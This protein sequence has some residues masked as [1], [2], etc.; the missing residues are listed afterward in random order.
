MEFEN[1]L[2]EYGNA[3]FFFQQCLSFRLF[4]NCVTKVDLSFDDIY[5][6]M[7]LSKNERKGEKIKLD[8]GELQLEGGCNW[9]CIVRL[10]DKWVSNG[11]R[12][13]Y[14]NRPNI[15]LQQRRFVGL[16]KI[17]LHVIFAFLIA[18]GLYWFYTFLYPVVPLITREWS[19]YNS[20]L[21][22]P[23]VWDTTLE[24]VVDQLRSQNATIPDVAT[25]VRWKEA[26]KEQKSL[27]VKASET[28]SYVRLISYLSSVIILFSLQ[29]YAIFE[30]VMNWVYGTNNETAQNILNDLYPFQRSV[31]G[32][33]QSP[34]RA[35]A[36]SPG[37]RAASPAR[38]AS[39]VQLNLT[40]AR[41]RLGGGYFDS[42]HNMNQIFRSVYMH[43]LS[44]ENQQLL[45]GS[46]WTYLG[47]FAKKAGCEG[48][49]ILQTI[50]LIMIV[51]VFVFY[52]SRRNWPQINGVPM[53]S[54]QINI[55][56]KIFVGNIFEGWGGTDAANNLGA[57][58][59][60]QGWAQ[61]SYSLFAM[62]RL[63]SKLIQPTL[64]KDSFDVTLGALFAAILYVIKDILYSGLSLASKIPKQIISIKNW[65]RDICTANDSPTIKDIDE[66]ILKQ[67]KSVVKNVQTKVKKQLNI[68]K[69]SRSRSPSKIKKTNS[70]VLRLREPSP[71]E[72]PKPPPKAQVVPVPLPRNFPF[73]ESRPNKLSVPPPPPPPGFQGIF[74][75]RPPQKV[76]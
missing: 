45:G 46:L 31:R 24:N 73:L 35:R 43:D 23:V 5:E 15:P 30:R 8:G 54:E 41:Q 20:K 4:N 16:V 68:E 37:R 10:F 55:A 61:F 33:S 22:S 62:G 29:F 56:L 11:I 50:I 19:E 74:P 13:S 32:R 58:L 64:P 47:N 49:A 44:N 76:V 57:I 25:I 40:N 69:V 63:I 67:V 38:G 21:T 70:E 60:N 51:S 39:G 66:K 48:L 7:I 26:A 14:G 2:F 53:T 18:Y 71:T 72:L 28:E 6:I 27:Y 17:A 34:G 65:F 59:R 52:G 3:K 42:Q 9:D 12:V 1:A 75:P 36:Q